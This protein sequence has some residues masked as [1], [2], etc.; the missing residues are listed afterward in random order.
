MKNKLKSIVFLL[1]IT[2]AMLV[3]GRA[4]ALSYNELLVAQ[5]KVLDASVYA[6]PTG[7][8]VNDSGTIYFISGA[9][10][11]PFTN[12]KA[13]KDLGYSLKN[14]VKG[15]LGNYTLSNGYVISTGNA[16][17]P[18]GGWLTY[19][20]TVYYNDAS[21]LIGVPSSAIFL[22]NGGLWKNL[23]KANK[24]DVAVLKQN[25]NLPVLTEND[26][27]VAGQ[28]G[29][30]F[31]GSQNGS[32][33]NIPAA[34]TPVVSTT[35]VTAS[36][37]S[38][39]LSTVIGNTGNSQQFALNN[40]DRDESVSWMAVPSSTTTW[41]SVFPTSGT[42]D[43]GGSQNLNL[44]VNTSVLNLGSNT[45]S[46]IFNYFFPSGESGT[47]TIP[48]TVNIGN[49][50]SLA[51]LA[52]S[53]NIYNI[54]YSLGAP[55]PTATTVLLTNLS[56]G[57]FAT[58]SQSAINQPAWLTCTY[59]TVA[60]VLNPSQSTGICVSVDPSQLTVPQTYKATVAITGNFANSPLYLTIN[61]TVTAPIAYL[62]QNSLN[63]STAAGV[64]SAGQPVNLSFVP[65][66]SY[67]WYANVNYNS[68]ADGWLSVSNG[69]AQINS[70]NAQAG[71]AALSFSASPGSL[72]PGNYSATVVISSS[73]SPAQFT[74][75]SLPVQ[76]TVLPGN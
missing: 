37:S 24:Y 10:K 33:Q 43:R 44:T 36:I 41:A 11:V 21:G 13:F 7:S 19:K 17:H 31:S 47:T 74:P 58:I 29:L 28:S 9:T 27:R 45:D 18:W 70:S 52:L 34:P 6:Y 1:T 48:V 20:N 38:V 64:T 12:L 69:S 65:S 23:I 57:T 46:L 71:N 3:G 73:A 49:G 8:V 62:S 68:V 56:G 16:Q 76:L 59:P 61:L 50:T 66:G 63:F 5:G 22:A 32:Q 15:N 67:G 42:I 2:L 30:Q 54:F 51:N 40:N 25:P 14:V 4:K 55:A 60:Q 72:P 53:Q 26:P 39:N 75:V 35:T